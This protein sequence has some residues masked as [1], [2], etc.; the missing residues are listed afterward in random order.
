MD[1]ISCSR[2]FEYT[3]VT[4]VINPLDG[5]S[6]NQRQPSVL[7]SNTSIGEKNESEASKEKIPVKEHE[8]IASRA[9]PSTEPKSSLVF[10][11]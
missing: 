1:V 11:A 5:M 7:F 3:A 2:T 4:F 6:L 8:D 10:S 9:S